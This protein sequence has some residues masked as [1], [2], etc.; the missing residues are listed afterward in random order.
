MSTPGDEGRVKNI[1]G[2]YARG[3]FLDLIKDQ[4]RTFVV[5]EA[6]GIHHINFLPE[7]FTRDSKGDDLFDFSSSISL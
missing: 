6:K 5:H 4:F 1:G 7:A 3:I 2:L